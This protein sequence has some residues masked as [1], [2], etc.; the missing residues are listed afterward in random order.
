MPKP[1]ADK[2]ITQ[3]KHRR[4]F[5]QRGGALPTNEI[6][7]AGANEAF[8]SF[9]DDDNPPGRGSLDPIFTP[10]LT[11]RRRFDQIGNSISAPDYASV[12]VNFMLKHGGIPWIDF[13]ISCP[14]N[15]Y[16]LAGTCKR[17]DD[18]INGWTDWVKIYSGAE[19]TSR[20]ESN[21]T[22]AEDSDDA[23]TIAVEWQ[24]AAIY[25]IGALNFG[26]KAAPEVEREVVD[27]A[28]ASGVE[29][30]NCGVTDDGTQRQYW[31]TKSSGAA[32]PGTPAEV[33]YTTNGGATWTNVNI[34]GLGGTTD[35]TGL[36]VVGNYIVVLDTAGN[37]YW[38]AELNTLTGVPGSWTNVTSGFV[39]SKQPTDLYV[40]GPN[41]IYFCANGGYIYKS[42]DIPSGVTVLDAGNATTNNLVR[43]HGDGGDTIVAV[44]ESG[45]IIRSL[46][47]G[48]TWATTTTSPTSATIRALSVRSQYLFWVGT[49]GGL[50]YYTVNGGETF[51]NAVNLPGGTYTVIDDI[52]HATDEVIHV[53]GRVSSTARLATSWNGGASWASSATATQR[54]Q[55]FP[56]ATRFN[57]IATPRDVDATTA[58]NY[59]ALGGLSGGG[60]DGALFLGV[61]NK[62]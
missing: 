37:G 40:V 41:E 3:A 35:P 20:S 17:T 46:N 13:D 30:G 52:V 12:T 47:R 27:G 34:T 26:E 39:A 56:T 42:T 31:V 50:V 57:R 24:C 21:Q 2:I 60:T 51:S 1:G 29:C 32:S 59:I 15:F 55:S 54:I 36:E 4:A 61:V 44:G 5:S 6:R 11:N 48:A 62:V 7:Y 28:Y 43:I 9:D 10:S 45:R 19:A 53:S 25:K 38:F 22:T 49:S 8:M 33:V 18:F 58:A 14:N 16:E 23:S